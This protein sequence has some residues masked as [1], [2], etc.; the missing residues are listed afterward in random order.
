MKSRIIFM[1]LFAGA[2]YACNTSGGNDPIG[3]VETRKQ[4]TVHGDAQFLISAYDMGIYE[5]EA[6][7]LADKNAA[8]PQVKQFAARMLKEYSDINNSITSIAKNEGVDMPSAMSHSMAERYNQLN[9]LNGKE[10][11]KDYAGVDADRYDNYIAN[12]EKASSGDFTPELKD[13][14]SGTI[15]KLKEHSESAQKLKKDLK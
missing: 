3:N 4:A 12:F 8:S 1:A 9:N 7:K 2:L 15:V 6:A 13:M 11:D 5:I 10:F 14:A